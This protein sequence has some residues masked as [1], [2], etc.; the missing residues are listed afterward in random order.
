MASSY[1]VLFTRSYGTTLKATLLKRVVLV[2]TT[3]ILPVVASAGTVAVISEGDSTVNVAADPLKFTLVAFAKSV[4]K[5]MTVATSYPGRL[6]V[7]AGEQEENGP[8]AVRF[9]GPPKQS[10][11]VRTVSQKM[12][13]FGQ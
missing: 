6:L 2:V 11:G 1:G 7:A 5:M 9:G 12:T 13:F 10:A 8:Q 3:W 4:P